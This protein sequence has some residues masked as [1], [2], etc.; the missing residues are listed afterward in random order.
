[1]ATPKALML[2]RGFHDDAAQA[3]RPSTGVA[4]SS[5]S[6]ELRRSLASPVADTSP[7][8]DRLMQFLK[9]LIG[10]F[11]NGERSPKASAPPWSGRT[12][13]IPCDF[14]RSAARGA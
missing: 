3:C 7:L 11:R 13:V 2:T 4:L 1:M 8:V 9:P 14:R 5:P 10:K 6:V 12:R